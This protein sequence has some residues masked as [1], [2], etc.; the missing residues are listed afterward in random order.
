MGKFDLENS[1]DKH[2][3]NPELLQGTKLEAALDP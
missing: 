3:A 1:T 2:S